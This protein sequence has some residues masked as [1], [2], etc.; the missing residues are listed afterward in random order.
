MKELLSSSIALFGH[1]MPGRPGSNG[2]FE[3]P[4]FEESSSGFG[5]H[6]QKSDA[7]VG[8][9]TLVGDRDSLA[10]KYRKWFVFAQNRFMFFDRN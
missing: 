9:G 3:C 10:Q 2:N 7:G 8:I 4:K 6:E 1:L 5:G